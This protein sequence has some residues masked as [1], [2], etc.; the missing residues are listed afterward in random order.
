MNA[1]RLRRLESDYNQ[2]RLNFDAD[3]R[4]DIAPVGPVPADKYRIVYKVPSLRLN[5]QGQPITVDVTT[6]E[7][8]LPDGYP[9]IPPVARTMPGDVVFHP[10]F[11]AAKICLMDFWAPATQLVDIVKEIGEMLQWQKFNI[12]APLNGV[13]AVWSQANQNFL[14][15]GNFKL[16]SQQV[17]IQ[18]R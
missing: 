10:N 3:P 2:L 14:P 12:R 6:V 7:L 18:F 5:G 16:G 1:A 13:A 11:N 9:R 4:V 17:R 15:V 8:N